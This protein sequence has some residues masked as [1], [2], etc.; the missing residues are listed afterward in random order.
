M[1]NKKKNFFLKKLKIMMF[2]SPKRK[3]TILEM[4]LNSS[5]MPKLDYQMSRIEVAS[6]LLK[7]TNN[8]GRLKNGVIR[9]TLLVILRAPIFPWSCQGWLKDESLKLYKKKNGIESMEGLW[10]IELSWWKFLK[11][12]HN[13]PWFQIYFDIL[14]SQLILKCPFGIFKSSKNQRNFFQDFCPSL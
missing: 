14:S 8:F 5:I 1:T 11:P 7:T 6:P 10:E 9:S 4:S 2:I 3:N 12:F 13:D